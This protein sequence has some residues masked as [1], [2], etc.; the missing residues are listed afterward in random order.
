[1]SLAREGQSLEG[2]RA[3]QTVTAV[4]EGTS[5]RNDDNDKNDDCDTR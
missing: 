3:A 4:I 5:R 2:L 1:M